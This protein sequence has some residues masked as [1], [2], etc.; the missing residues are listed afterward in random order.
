MHTYTLKLNTLAFIPCLLNFIFAET[1]HV[2]A[3][4]KSYGGSGEVKEIIRWQ[5]GV[6]MDSRGTGVAIINPLTDD[7][8]Y[9]KFDTVHHAPVS[10]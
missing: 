1:F 4:S 2:H 3:L 10:V 5:G 6:N 8:Q 7:I 9:Q